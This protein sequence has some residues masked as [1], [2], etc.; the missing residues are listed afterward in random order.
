MCQQLGE[1][2]LGNGQVIA[3]TSFHVGGVLQRWP[4]VGWVWDFGKGGWAGGDDFF[5]CSL[6]GGF[7]G[8]PYRSVSAVCVAL[9]GESVKFRGMRS[10]V[11]NVGGVTV[12]RCID[13][14]GVGRR[15]CRR[16]PPW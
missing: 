14:N 16:L 11:G 1:E 8:L 13:V 9:E 10:W 2:G 5:V 12:A 3:I 4:Q 6:V 7:K 15:A